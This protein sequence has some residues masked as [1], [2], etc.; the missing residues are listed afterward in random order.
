MNKSISIVLF[1]LITFLSFPVLNSASIPPEPK[2]SSAQDYV[3]IEVKNM[4]MANVFT[5]IG[6]YTGANIVC[7]KSVRGKV[8]LKMKDIYFEKAIELVCKTNNLSYRKIGNTF[9]IAPSKE[10]EDAFDV[11]FNRVF[12]LQFATAHNIAS[13]IK[14][15]FKR[16][17]AKAFVSIDKRNNTIIVSGSNETIY[18]IEKLI[19]N[20]DVPIHM[21]KISL[22]MNQI[23]AKGKENIIFKT[24]VLTYSGKG[25]RIKSGN[26]QKIKKS[27]KKDIYNESESGY[28]FRINCTVN[29]DGFISI[30]MDGELSVTEITPGGPI[31]FYKEIT[32]SFSA[33]NG[34][35]I[36]LCSFYDK[37]LDSTFTLTVKTEI[38]IEK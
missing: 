19:Q 25:I 20:L 18:A 5:M 7:H 9:V 22:A 11:G 12:K 17:D 13:I 14:G 30:D 23:K 21:V 31:N 38:V 6:K 2:Q 1:L 3:S 16:P 33:K 24:D 27:D 28:R 36:S 35:K 8:T 10:L 34:K 37:A 26:K 29:D 15:I 32:N 4:D